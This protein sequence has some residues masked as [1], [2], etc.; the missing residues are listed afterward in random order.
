MANR[1]VEFVKKYAKEN[2]ISYTCSMC[3]IKTKGLYKPLDKQETKG[4]IKTIKIKQ[5]KQK[6]IN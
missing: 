2:N 5:R 4:E 6:A 1:W 3:K